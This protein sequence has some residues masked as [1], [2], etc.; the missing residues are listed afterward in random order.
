MPAFDKYRTTYPPVSVA[1]HRKIL[2][3]PIFKSAHQKARRAC[4]LAK[5]REERKAERLHEK[6]KQRRA[7][8]QRLIQETYQNASKKAL[9]AFIAVERPAYVEVLGLIRSER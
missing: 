1:E 4:A 5:D 3:H 2:A 8:A 9:E 7:E 6:E